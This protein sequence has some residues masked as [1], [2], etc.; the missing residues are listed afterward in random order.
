MTTSRPLRHATHLVRYPCDSFEMTVINLQPFKDCEGLINRNCHEGTISELKRW[1]SLCKILSK[2][3]I[4]ITS[5]FVSP[6]PIATGDDDRIVDD[7]REV[8]DVGAKEDPP[9]RFAYEPISWGA[10]VNTWQHA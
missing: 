6:S 5:L 2:F 9:I 10:H 8:A 7:L 1:L 3:M 4:V